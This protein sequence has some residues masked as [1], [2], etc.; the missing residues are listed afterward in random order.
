MYEG[1]ANGYDGAIKVSVT[2]QNSAIEKIEVLETGDNPTMFTLVEEAV[3]PGVIENNTANGIDAMSDATYS[4]QGLL[5]AIADAL[6][7]AA[8][9]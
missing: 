2:I 7:K 1:E 9:E 3:V 6:E 8:A 4:S 5:D